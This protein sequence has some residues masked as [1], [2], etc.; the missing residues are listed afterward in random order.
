MLFNLGTAIV[1][2]GANGTDP[3]ELKMPLRYSEKNS[4]VAF[5]LKFRQ[6]HQR[7]RHST[8]ES[9][10][11][12]RNSILFLLLRMPEKFS[13]PFLENKITRNDSFLC[14]VLKCCFCLKHPRDYFITEKICSV[15]HVSL[16]SGAE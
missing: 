16:F 12:N 4:R 9:P 6:L 3:T 8:E 15:S 2:A 13:H 1:L 10:N 14:R 5:W 7:Q 11:S